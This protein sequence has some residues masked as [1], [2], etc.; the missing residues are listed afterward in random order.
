MDLSTF[1]LTDRVALVTG[2]GRGIGKGIAVSFAKVGAHVVITDIDS[3]EAETTAAEIRALGRRALALTADV[4]K[5][6][7]VADMVQKTLDEFGRID[8]LVNNA[9]GTLGKRFSFM[10]TSEDLWDEMV[11]LNLKHVFLCTKAV[12]EVMIKQKKGSIISISSNAGQGPYPPAA[13]Y[14][15]AKAGVINLTQTLAQAWAPYNIRVNAIAPG[16]VETRWLLDVFRLHPELRQIALDSIPLRRLAQP[17]DIA[18][19]AIYLASDAAAFITGEV[20]GVNG[21]QLTWVAWPAPQPQS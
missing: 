8:I 2:G 17:E 16:V 13:G 6:D 14:G 7:Q 10:E 1:G 20:I 5:S 21:G 9:G 15:A 4:Q 3:P 11:K 19:A 12:G 18:G